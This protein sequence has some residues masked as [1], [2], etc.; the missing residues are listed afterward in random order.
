MG[1]E[2]SNVGSRQAQQLHGGAPTPFAGDRSSQWANKGDPT[3]G[4]GGEKVREVKD[5]RRFA[6]GRV[7]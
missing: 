4:K 5:T 6:D 1:E 7:R 3:P 2:R